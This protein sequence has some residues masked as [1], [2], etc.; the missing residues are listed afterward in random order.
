[1]KTLQKQTRPLTLKETKALGKIRLSADKVLKRGYRIHYLL[2]AGLVG[3]V[4]V[5]LATWTKYDFL[6]FVFG[7][8]AVLSFA[9]VV[10]MPYEI[11]KSIRSS[12]RTITAVDKVITDNNIVVARVTARQIALAKEYEDESDLYIVE[13]TD[14]TILYMWDTDYNLKKNFP[15]FEF[16]IYDDD[17]YKLIGRKLNSLSEKV[18]P[19]V[20]N[21][22]AKWAYLKRTGIAEHMTIEKRDFKK[23]VEQINGTS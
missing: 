19:I 10:L 3:A 12:K 8:I 17:F 2:V 5:Y 4:F 22:K 23:L 14:N 18:K 11:Y 15:C 7:T 20:I 16:E 1:V 21:P 9:C 13:M 6:T